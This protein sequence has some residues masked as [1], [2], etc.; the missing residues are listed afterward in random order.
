MD[1]KGYIRLVGRAKELIIRGGEN[2]YPKE[3]E[4]LLHKHPL[5]SEAYVCLFV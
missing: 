4:E 2:V 3:V 1:E 5:I